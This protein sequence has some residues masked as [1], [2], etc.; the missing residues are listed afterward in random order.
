LFIDARTMGTM[1]GRTQR[2]LTDDDIDRVVSVHQEWRSLRP[3]APYSGVD[4]LAR[5]ATVKEI[6]RHDYVLNPGRY[7]AASGVD[8]DVDIVVETIQELRRELDRLHRQA[9]EADATFD[10]QLSRIAT[11]RP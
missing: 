5:S 6:R 11:C 8:V 7:V 10:H 1:M 9:I 3:A 4:G 2:V